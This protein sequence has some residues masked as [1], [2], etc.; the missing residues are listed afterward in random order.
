MTTLREAVKDFLSQKRIAVVGVSSTRDIQAN[1][2]YRKF[3]GAGYQVFAVNPKVQTVE[4]DPCYPDLKSILEGLDGVVIITRPETTEKI[5]YQC[6]EAHVSRVWIH[7]SHRLLGN[8][9]SEKAVQ[10]CRENGISV[11][12]G[13][14]P[15]MFLKPVDFPHLCLRETLRLIGGLPRPT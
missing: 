5:A 13:A 2:I 7:R 6:V 8:S 4:G 1:R 14:C 10:L 12:P 9:V 15:M 11:I 3:R